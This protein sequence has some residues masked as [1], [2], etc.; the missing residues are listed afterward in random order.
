MITLPHSC[1]EGRH[2]FSV[3]EKPDFRLVEKRSP[4]SSPLPTGDAIDGNLGHSV[5]H[6]KSYNAEGIVFKATKKKD[7]IR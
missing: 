6:I 1:F 4:Q 3:I 2:I 7:V 5:A